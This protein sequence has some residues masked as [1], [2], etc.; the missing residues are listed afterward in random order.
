MA[1]WTATRCSRSSTACNGGKPMALVGQVLAHVV[2]PTMQL[3]GSTT[4]AFIRS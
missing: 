3:S 1:W 4:T 2:Q